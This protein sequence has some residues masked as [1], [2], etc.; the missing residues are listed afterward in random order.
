[1]A[2]YLVLYSLKVNCALQVNMHGLPR[3]PLPLGTDNYQTLQHNVKASTLNKTFAKKKLIVSE[4]RV[5]KNP[6]SAKDEI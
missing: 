1:M 3:S 6:K 2:L 5:Q 4:E